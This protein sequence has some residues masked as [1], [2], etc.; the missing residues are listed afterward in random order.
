VVKY[1][2]RSHL[3]LNASVPIING[4]FN[5]THVRNPGAAWGML[6]G[7][8]TWLTLLS[9]VMLV[10]LIK[11]RRTFIGGIPANRWALGC[12]L[13]GIVGNFIDRIRLTFI[14]DFLDF[15]SGSYHFPSFNIADAAICTGVGLYILA[16]SLPARAMSGEVPDSPK[17]L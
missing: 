16:S 3:A 14:V 9:F 15:Y 11:F 12:M 5:L 2:I 4:F 13:G 17:S 6:G 7:F 1:L 8:N 10:L